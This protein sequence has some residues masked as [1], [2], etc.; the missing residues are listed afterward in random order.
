M[1]KNSI[2]VQF[3]D[4]AVVENSTVGAVFEGSEATINS[5]GI[6][7]NRKQVLG[8]L[9]KEGRKVALANKDGKTLIENPDGFAKDVDAAVKEISSERPR[10]NIALSFLGEIEK[11]AKTVGE[12]GV[13]LV[14]IIS[15]VKDFIP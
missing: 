2:K 6:G 3:G 9:L 1:S 5:S 14:D 12:I 13:P 10:K 7:Q 8:A 4:H 15:K 11:V